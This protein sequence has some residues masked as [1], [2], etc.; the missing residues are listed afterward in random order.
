M[1]ASPGLIIPLFYEMEPTH[2]RY[3]QGSSSPYEKSFE[4]YYSQLDRYSREEI[5]GWKH[6]LEQICCRSGWSLDMTG[7]FEAQLVKKVVNDII[8]TLDR[9]PLQVAK[10]PVGLETVKK[11]LIQKLHL[12]SAQTAVRFG[13]WG[14]G[15]IGK[16]TVAKAAYNEACNDFDAASFVFNVR[17][18]SLTKL[19]GQIL[20]DLVN[21]EEELQ[22]VEKGKYL[23]ADR[24]RGIR[25]LV[26]LDD[27]DDR[28]QLDA[29]AGHWLSPGSCL[30]ITSRD[31]HILNTAHISSVC[32]H[33][34]SGLEES[35]GLQLLSWHAF[36]RPSP[37]PGYEVLSKRIVQA[38]KGHP[39][40]LE[41]IGAFLYD[42]Q[43]DTDIDSWNEILDNFTVNKDIFKTLKI[44]FKGLSAEER[45]IFLDIACL[46]IGERTTNPILFWKSMYK[47]VRIAITNLSMKLLIRID[48]K[49]VFDM[50]DLVQDM[51]QMVAEEEQTRQWQA[52]Q[53]SS[54]SKNVSNISGLRLYKGDLRSLKMLGTPS[55][56]YLH[57][58][59]VHI[60]DSIDNLPPSLRWLKVDSCSFPKTMH[61][62]ILFEEVILAMKNKFTSVVDSLPQLRIMDLTGCRS[63]QNLPDSIGHLS[64]LQSLNLSECQK[65]DCLPNTISNLSQLLY[66]NLSYCENLLYLPDSIGNL[67]QLQYLNLTC[68]RI[69][70]EL[71]DSIGKLSQLK[72]L[73]L[74]WSEKLESLPKSISNLSKLEMLD[75]LRCHTAW[76]SI[77]YSILILPELCLLG[78]PTRVME[79][80]WCKPSLT[81]NQ[82]QTEEW[83]TPKFREPMTEFRATLAPECRK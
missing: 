19:Q 20:K 77:P 61:S 23:L 18:T 39:L 55:L 47:N 63:L 38:C 76:K 70:I 44:S 15:G 27:V 80:R 2:V 9:V 17:S 49:D 53:S 32:I 33:Q 42:K 68:C 35:E 26:I 36:L 64:H 40:S 16:T 12:G 25:A 6:A 69:L 29:L 37:I 43:N 54:S 30:I 8:K 58:E 51:G 11:D 22:S 48:E 24:L 41:I 10:Y 59:Q 67:S 83:T 4:K 65:L 45:E 31:R 52:A 5:D 46:F 81:E 28:V 66:L 21:Y 79:W 7:S 60:E 34:M 1:L 74:S 57:L 78:L 72:E 50:H 82:D 73:S 3:P 13:I 75:M 56:H 14:I 62:S 71:P